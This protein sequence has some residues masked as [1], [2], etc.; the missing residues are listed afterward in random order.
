MAGAGTRTALGTR[1]ARSGRAELEGEIKTEERPQLPRPLDDSR[2]T[3]PFEGLALEGVHTHYQAYV[4]QTAK[5]NSGD[6]VVQKV[7]VEQ[8]GSASETDRERIPW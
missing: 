6:H 4:A 3:V 1:A 8:V 2:A 7:A 5:R